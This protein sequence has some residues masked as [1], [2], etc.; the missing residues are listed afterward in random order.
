MRLAV[1]IANNPAA[2]RTSKMSV[3]KKNAMRKNAGSMAMRKLHAFETV[4]GVVV[5][6]ISD[7]SISHHTYLELGMLD[8]G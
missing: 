1:K 3:M 8:G 5:K 4:V 7:L 2:L 6:C